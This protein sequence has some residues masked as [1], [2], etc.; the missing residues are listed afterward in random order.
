MLENP[1]NLHEVKSLY[2]FAAKDVHGVIVP[3]NKYKGHVCIVVNIATKCG[4]AKNHFAELMQLYDQ[5]EESKG[6]QILAFPCNQFGDCE[7]LENW[8]IADFVNEN[9]IRFDVFEKVEVNGENANP[10]W[11]YLKYK[12]PGTMK[13][14]IKWNFTKFIVD[15]MGQPVERHGP[16]TTPR[17]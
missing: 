11:K 5:Y 8:E 12:K 4:Y 6:L 15:R 14:N 1:V 3:L 16:S 13:G 7:P 2:E 17:T 10:I 9:K